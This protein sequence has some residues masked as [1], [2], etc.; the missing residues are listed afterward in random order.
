MFFV[1]DGNDY[2]LTEEE[3][4]KSEQTLNELAKKLEFEHILLRKKYEER[5]KD[6]NE[7]KNSNSTSTEGQ[8]DPSIVVDYL[9]RVIYPE[10]DFNEVRVAVVGNVDAGKST[11]LGKDLDL[12][13]VNFR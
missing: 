7:S 1:I 4:V 11:L 2:G 5:S 3:V 10:N 13:F 6:Q 12:T 9:I 8:A